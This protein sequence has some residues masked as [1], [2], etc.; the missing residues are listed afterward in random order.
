MYTECICSAENNWPEHKL[1]QVIV[2]L[3]ER[4]LPTENKSI[5]RYALFTALIIP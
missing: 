4:N 2:I 5:M 1:K 3:Y